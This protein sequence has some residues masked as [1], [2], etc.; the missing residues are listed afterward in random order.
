MSLKEG[1]KGQVTIFIIIAI[2]IIAFGALVYLYYP[3]IFPGSSNESKN[4]ATFIQECL[5]EEI[6][7]N[8]K[9]I[10][11]Q[12]GNYIINGSSGYFY[13]KN[14]E[15]DGRYVR[16]LCY[17]DENYNVPCINQE[18]FLREHVELEVLNSINESIKTCF[19]N[20]VK[21]YDTKGYNTDLKRGKTDVQIIPGEV[22][23]DFNSTLTLTKGDESET[24]RNFEIKIKSNLYEILE[25]SK[26]ILVWEMNIGDSMPE[27]YM[28]NNPYIRVEKHRKDDDIKIYVVSEINSEEDFRFAVR[29]FA[30]PVGFGDIN[31]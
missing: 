20:M 18:P 15:D 11:S 6:E 26:N 13:K 9:T 30:S 3:K 17:T 24:Y 5:E 31:I 29:S 14:N 21:D 7:D 19:D 23:T 12:G 22:Y 25:V 16:Y 10:S 4:P 8:L 1:K 28:Y 27:A 2:L